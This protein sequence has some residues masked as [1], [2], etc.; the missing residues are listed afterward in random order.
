VSDSWPPPQGPEQPGE[1]P[2]SQDASSPPYPPAQP[3]PF[4]QPPYPPAQPPPYGQPPYPP[5]QP[6]PYAQPY[7][8]TPPAPY[9]R[10]PQPFTDQ[11]G[12]PPA[13]AYPRQELL[14]HEVRP[15]K[16][17]VPL[18]I[19][20]VVTLALVGGGIAAWLLLRDNGDATR[21]QYCTEITSAT[22][23]SDIT[24]ILGG[25]PRAAFAELHK[26]ADLA[27]TGVAADWKTLTAL[28][29]SAQKS[30]SSANFS[31]VVAAAEA[32]RSIIADSN[33]HCG[34]TFKAPSLP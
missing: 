7:G 10:S 19:G 15:R 34:T 14:P 28:L 30:Q 13:T 4:G 22:R 31:A 21:A 17:R 9:R 18:V 24:S 12:Q 1:D 3:P 25:G 5:A 32:L 8:G 2:H 6:P 11:F 16:R 27:P 33:A 23:G 26:L 29:E 20:L